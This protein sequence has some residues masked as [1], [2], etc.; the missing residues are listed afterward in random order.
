MYFKELLVAVPAALFILGL[1]AASAG[2]TI[3]EVGVLVCATDKWDEKELAKDHKLVDY[4]SRCVIVPD[5]AKATKVTELCTGKFEYMPD[6]SWKGAGVCT[7]TAHPG[8]DTKTLSWEEGSHFNKVFKFT[9]TGGTGKW[10]D[11]KGGGTY[12]YEN[13]TDTLAVG[14]SEGAIELP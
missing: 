1:G 13:L 9:I 8:G 4:A 11:A 14:R 5:D 10:K 2:Q 7:D 12:H 6:K 3:N